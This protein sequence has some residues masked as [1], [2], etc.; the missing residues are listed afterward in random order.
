MV[1][2]LL[3]YESYTDTCIDSDSQLYQELLRSSYHSESLHLG[4]TGLN[5]DNNF[6]EPKSLLLDSERMNM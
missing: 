6:L 3:E 2:Q 1:N 5:L 4:Q